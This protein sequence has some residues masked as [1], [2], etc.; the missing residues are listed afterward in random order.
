MAAEPRAGL[1]Y[2]P[3]DGT[4]RLYDVNP[5]SAERNAEFGNWVQDDVAATADWTYEAE[6]ELDGA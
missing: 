3:L 4:V 2:S 6:A 1:A 5:E